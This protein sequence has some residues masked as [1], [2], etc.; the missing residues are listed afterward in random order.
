[1][2]FTKPIYN[3]GTISTDTLN[4]DDTVWAITTTGLGWLD[5]RIHREFKQRRLLD[6][7]ELLRAFQNVL[8]HLAGG[9]FES[10][11]IQR[12]KAIRSFSAQNHYFQFDDSVG[13]AP[14]AQRIGPVLGLNWFTTTQLRR[15]F[16]SWRD[17]ATIDV[18]YLLGLERGID[19]GD[20]RKSCHGYR[21]QACGTTPWNL[22][23]HNS[24][25]SKTSD[26]GKRKCSLQILASKSVFG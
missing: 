7:C 4:K 20:D 14:W 19:A 25:L 17:L 5:Q 13:C 15:H 26:C 22:V 16:E 24:R 23:F 18:S 8:R 3:A 2:S 21:E 1:M 12:E 10:F 9:F 6:S 11:P